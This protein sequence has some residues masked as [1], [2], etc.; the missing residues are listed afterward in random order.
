V[1]GNFEYLINLLKISFGA[2]IGLN[3]DVFTQS[4]FWRPRVFWASTPPEQPIMLY[5]AL[6]RSLISSSLITNSELCVPAFPQHVTVQP[7]VQQPNRADNRV[8]IEAEAPTVIIKAASSP[9]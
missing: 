1:R 4:G 7:K 6:I 3:S 9:G 8:C 2:E 5:L